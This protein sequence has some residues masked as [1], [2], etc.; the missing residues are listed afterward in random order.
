M[1]YAC[2]PVIIYTVFGITKDINEIFLENHIVV[3]GFHAEGFTDVRD[4]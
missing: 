3:S 4:V 2:K 1:Y